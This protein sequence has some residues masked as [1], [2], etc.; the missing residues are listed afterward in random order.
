M[1]WQWYHDTF[2][3]GEIHLHAL[4]GII[5]TRR[6]KYQTVEIVESQQYGKMLILDGDCQSSVKDEYIYHECLNEPAMVCHPDPRRILVVGGGEGASL[7]ELLRFKSVEHIDM[8]D[9]DEEANQLYEQYLPEYHQGAFH[10]PRVSLHFEDARGYIERQPEHSYNVIIEDLTDLFEGGP[11]LV[12]FT[13]QFYEQAFRV[14]DDDGT[15]CVTASYLKP[16]NVAVHKRILD[17]IRAVF[18]VARSLYSYVG[19][20]DVP[21]SYI[22][23]SKKTDP[24]SLD[25]AAVDRILA[26]RVD[27]VSGL[28]FYD[29]VTHERIFRMPKDIRGLLSER[30]EPLEDTTPF[31]IPPKGE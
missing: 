12:L 4:T 22:L 2:E 24:L 18:P 29:G 3:P 19:A 27:D 20:Y 10:D 5:A 11:S 15:L 23:A 21:W 14:L 16:T 6:T 25:A 28:R 13:K 7:R 31:G 9:I 8:C 26:E 1:A 30:G 17:S